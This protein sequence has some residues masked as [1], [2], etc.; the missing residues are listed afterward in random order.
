[1][2]NVAGRGGWERTVSRSPQVGLVHVR[3]GDTTNCERTISRPLRGSCHV[4]SP[5][6]SNLINNGRITNVT[7]LYLLN[8]NS[9]K[10]GDLET[11][12]RASIIANLLAPTN[13]P[14]V[15]AIMRSAARKPYIRR[16]TR[17]VCISLATAASEGVH[18]AYSSLYINLGR[19][20]LSPS[21]L[22]PP[23][24]VSEPLR[25]HERREYSRRNI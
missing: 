17:G 22:Q 4:V 13:S 5:W 11:R 25:Q 8:D 16:G 3:N 1:M 20:I 6:V 14:G 9:N 18:S 19:I 12:F 24:F 21:L 2:R 7:S 15:V 23:S 10:F